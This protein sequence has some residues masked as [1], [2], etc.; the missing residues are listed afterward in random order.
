MAGKRVLTEFEARRTLL[1][2]GTEGQPQGL[3]AGAVLLLPS[4]T[5]EGRLVPVET[6]YIRSALIQCLFV[7][8]IVC[9]HVCVCVC[10]CRSLSLSLCVCVCVFLSVYFFFDRKM[11]R[12]AHTESLPDMKHGGCSPT[13]MNF[14]QRGGSKG[15]CPPQIK[16]QVLSAVHK[17]NNA[18]RCFCSLLEYF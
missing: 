16:M 14:E 9:V 5:A 17:R 10:V 15:P 4:F 8:Y 6:K 7:A 11:S 2:S 12:T 13:L 18:L 1:S 3:Q